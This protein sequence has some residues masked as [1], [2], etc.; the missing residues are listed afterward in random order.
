MLHPAPHATARILGNGII[1]GI[2][3]D[4]IFINQKWPPQTDIRILG[5]DV[6][7]NPDDLTGEH[8][9]EID[10]GVTEAEKSAMANQL[11][12]L[13]QFGTQAGIQ[14]GIMTPMHIIKAQRKKYRLLGIK[15]DDLMLT[16][17]Q[18][19]MQQQQ[20]QMMQQAQQQAMMNQQMAGGQPPGPPPTGNPPPGNPPPSAP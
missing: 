18:Y 16:E 6:T 3:R 17:Q 20:Q 13:I 1:L 2:I 19:A 10:I 14:M 7:V 4:F 11:D 8:E 5:T 9:I 15:V 12:L